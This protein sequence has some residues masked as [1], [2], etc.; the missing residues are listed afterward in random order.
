MAN[1]AFPR[2]MGLVFFAMFALYLSWPLTPIFLQNVRQ[3]TLGEIG[4]IGSFNAL[5]V[6]VL[7]L[8]LGAL[9]PWL[10]F[11]IAQGL[12][13]ISVLLLWS[14][15]GLPWFALGYFLAGGF[16]TSR[17]LVTAQVEGLIKRSE[18]GLAYGVAETVG[19][20]VQIVASPLAG[21]L[22]RLAP[23]LPYPVAL[24]L[25]AASVALTALFAPRRGKPPAAARAPLDLP[26]IG[27]D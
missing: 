10:G 21:V 23:S 20:S 18:M 2:L 4:L 5:G 27:R 9:A 7:N 14:G 22:Y 19:G 6:V 25:I 24:A 8:T 17:L 12:V 11:L 3:V 26:N 13:G 15:T 16:R 1:K